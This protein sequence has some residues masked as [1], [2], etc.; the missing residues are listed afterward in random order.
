MSFFKNF[1]T[2]V[3]S[4][5]FSAPNNILLNKV[6]GAHVLLV[7]SNEP[8][9]DHINTLKA[10]HRTLNKIKAHEEGNYKPLVSKELRY[11]NAAARDY[12]I[13]CRKYVENGGHLTAQGIA[14][15]YACA[16]QLDV[17]SQWLEKYVQ[18][19]IPHFVRYMSVENL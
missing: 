17:N 16:S 8:V 1:A 10:L 6:W 5:R 14:N 13:N 3:N 12:A 19:E 11:L 18:D 15:L 4:A 7:R 9:V 2:T